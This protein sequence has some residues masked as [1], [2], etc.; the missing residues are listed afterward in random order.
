VEIFVA[1]CPLIKGIRHHYSAASVQCQV[2]F[3]TLGQREH[4]Y[5]EQGF[6]AC[7]RWKE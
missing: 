7:K 5:V 2:T 3:Q 4:G 6:Q 1:V